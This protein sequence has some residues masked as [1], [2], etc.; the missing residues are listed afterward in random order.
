VQSQ[1]SDVVLNLDRVNPDIRIYAA[2]SIIARFEEK[3]LVLA[4]Y[5]TCVTTQEVYNSWLDATR[6]NV[7]KF[8]FP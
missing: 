8:K 3:D 7:K 2:K 4:R 1:N 6:K 5:D